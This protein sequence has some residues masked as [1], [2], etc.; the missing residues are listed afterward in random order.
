MTL[1]FS[2]G[3]RGCNFVFAQ[4]IEFCSCVN[5][6]TKVVGVCK[7]LLAELGVEFGKSLVYLHCLAALG[8]A[9]VRA[10]LSKVFV[11]ANQQPVALSIEAKRLAL[12]VELFDSCVERWVELNRIL[13][14]GQLWR[15]LFFDLV[16]FV[17]GVA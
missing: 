17:I 1:V 12:V 3:C 10:G 4:A 5:E 6:D 2:K 9:Q 14:R 11:V 15:D 8:F 7:Q 13:M 16:D